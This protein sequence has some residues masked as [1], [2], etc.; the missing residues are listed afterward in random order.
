[1]KKEIR[2]AASMNVRPQDDNMVIEGKAVVFDTPALLYTDTLGNEYYERIA[3]R[4]VG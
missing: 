2:S 1:M 3:P 4:R